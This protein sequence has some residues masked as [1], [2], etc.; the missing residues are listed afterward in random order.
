MTT[1]KTLGKAIKSP[2]FKQVGNSMKKPIITT[3]G[4]TMKKSVNMFHHNS[5]SVKNLALGVQNK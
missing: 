5:N 3:F 4:N 2:L 1:L